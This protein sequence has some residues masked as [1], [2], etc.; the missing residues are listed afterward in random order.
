MRAPQGHMAQS[1]FP[2]VVLANC[3]FALNEFLFLLNRFQ[4]YALPSRCDHEHFRG[5]M[6]EHHYPNLS[7]S[8][9]ERRTEVWLYDLEL[10]IFLLLLHGC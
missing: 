7:P 10:P 2:S 1:P 9:G 3:T 4:V 5:E 6:Y 8:S